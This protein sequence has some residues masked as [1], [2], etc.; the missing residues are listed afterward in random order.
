MNGISIGLCLTIDWA[1]PTSRN[2]V[3]HFQSPK[4]SPKGNPLRFNKYFCAL[5]SSGLAPSD[6]F[7]VIGV[8]YALVHASTQTKTDLCKELECPLPDLQIDISFFKG[9]SSF[10]ILH[11][12]VTNCCNSKS[13]FLRVTRP[14]PDILTPYFW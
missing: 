9:K 4:K 13:C 8:K 7:F 5:S 14:D 6:A 11:N 3:L 12:K 1:C 10:L 2:D